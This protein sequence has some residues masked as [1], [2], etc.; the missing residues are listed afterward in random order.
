MPTITAL[1]AQLGESSM[2]GRVSGLVAKRCGQDEADI[3]RPGALSASVMGFKGG[4]SNVAQK[5]KH[6]ISGIFDR[7]ITATTVMM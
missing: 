2:R 6:V 5:G 4:F 1:L 7:V 3:E